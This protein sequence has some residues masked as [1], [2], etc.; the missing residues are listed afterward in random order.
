ML[1]LTHRPRRLVYLCVLLVAVALS[2][3][4]LVYGSPMRALACGANLVLGSS[5][6]CD[7]QT[8]LTG[9]TS[10]SL[11]RLQNLD[12]GTSAYAV[13][14]SSPAAIALLGQSTSSRGVLG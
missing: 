9:T 11:L 2:A 13:F 7:A 1:G 8:T 14:A 12:P 10:N 4:S 3:A 5:N 6:S